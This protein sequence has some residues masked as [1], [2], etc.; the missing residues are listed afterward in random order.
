MLRVE[1]L[2][3]LNFADGIFLAMVAVLP[4]HTVF[5]EAWISWKPW[6]VLLVLVIVF[7]LWEGIRERE[8]PYHPAVSI[9][10]IVFAA[11][12][13]VGFPAEP[14]RERFFQLGLAIA[15]GAMVMLVTERRLLQPGLV[16]RML[17]VVFWSGAAMGVTAIFFSLVNLGVFG[18]GL[19]DTIN[20]LPGVFRISK[21]AYLEEG[22]IA[23]TNWHQDPG[24]GA[25]W[26]VLWAALALVAAAR[27]RATGWGWVDATVIGMLGFAVMMA[28]SRTG[29]AALPLG[30]IIVGFALTRVGWVTWKWVGKHLAWAAMI[31]TLLVASM[32]VVD[33]PLVGGDVDLQFAF[34]LSQGWDLLADITG[35]F[36][37]SDVAFGDRFQPSEER[38]DVWP[39]YIDM[40]LENPIVGVGLGV[41][42]LTNSIMQEP[43]NLII[44]L[45]AETGV[46]GL[47][48][49]LGL[50]VVIVRSG[51]GKVAAALLI[52]TFLPSMTQTVLFEPTWW[53]VGGVYLSE[54]LSGYT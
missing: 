5:F 6:L 28:F 11:A 31:T 15:V 9:A 1:Q 8:W 10:L 22:F 48:A 36:E 23:L 14:Y 49:F 20:D 21:P 3:K 53:F 37:P 35:L 12:L 24:Y 27:D 40:F 34:R 7:D 45:L 41:G 30:L 26:T 19:L 39:E 51:S 17:T 2:P 29:W 16:D 54:S 38:A 50:M 18:T 13:L 47:L 52:V 32:F 42:W 4:L 44:E 33:K 46:V 25:A 43:H